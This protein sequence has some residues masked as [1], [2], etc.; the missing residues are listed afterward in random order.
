MTDHN[1][2]LSNS[3]LGTSSDTAQRVST[4][5]LGFCQGQKS[6]PDPLCARAPLTTRI[7]DLWL[8]PL[9]QTFKLQVVA[10]RN[11]NGKSQSQSNLVC[12][13]SSLRAQKAKAL[14]CAKSGVSA[15]FRKEHQKVYNISRS[16]CAKSA[17]L[18]TFW[19]YFWKMVET[20]LFAHF[21]D[22]VFWALRLES[23]YTNQIM[24]FGALTSSLTRGGVLAKFWTSFGSLSPV[25]RVCGGACLVSWRPCT[26]PDE[27]CVEDTLWRKQ[28]VAK[29]D[30][31]S[32]LQGLQKCS[33]ETVSWN[34]AWKSPW[35]M[36]WNFRWKFAVPLSL[37]NEARKCPEL[38]TT[39]CT[40]F[41]TRRFAAANT[42]FHGVLHSA[43]SCPWYLGG[44]LGQFRNFLW[45]GCLRLW[46]AKGP[47]GPETPKIKAANT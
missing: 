17:V 46:R 45:F 7:C 35:K 9:K 31:L 19:C 1:Y 40:P 34:R 13:D 18:C 25:R 14:K 28:P 5:R 8:E 43:D 11:S 39:N 2:E 23:K 3:V 41:F 15:D 47:T 33:R 16:F 32:S 30:Y 20:P 12:F 36:P 29:L 42:K 38:F 4:Q 6:T 21:N 27:K 37:G 22:F 44:V 26:L 24:N 10:I